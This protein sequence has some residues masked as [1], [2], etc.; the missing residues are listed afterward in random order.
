M[1]NNEN[2]EYYHIFEKCMII[3]W[4]NINKF[5][6]ISN[7]FRMKYNTLLNQTIY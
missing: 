7:Q 5:Q 2:M 3:D 4:D 1:E 6:K